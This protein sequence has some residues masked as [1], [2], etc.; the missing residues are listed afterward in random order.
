MLP[1]FQDKEIR[2]VFLRLFAQLLQGYRWCLH[3]IRIHPEPV[4]RF[5]KVREGR[6]EPGWDSPGQETLPGWQGVTSPTC[7]PCTCIPC[8][9]LR[10]TAQAGSAR[11]LLHGSARREH[12]W[13]CESGE[14]LALLRDHLHSSGPVSLWPCIP[15]SLSTPGL[16]F[17]CPCIPV[18]LC[19]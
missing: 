12:S 6:D 16:V 4:I 10:V 8:L 5:H 7:L 13:S 1:L 2:A 14:I 15:V 11:V 17:L 9:S 19:P 18:P 3:I